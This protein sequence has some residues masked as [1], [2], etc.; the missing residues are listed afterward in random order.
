MPGKELPQG[1]PLSTVQERS[2]LSLI[3]QLVRKIS[4]VPGMYFLW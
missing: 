3:L 2:R 1:F 4:Y